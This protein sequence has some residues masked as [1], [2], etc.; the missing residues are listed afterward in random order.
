MT[1]LRHVVLLVQSAVSGLVALGA[2]VF[3]LASHSPQLGFLAAVSAM[4]ALVPVVVAAGLGA[5]WGWARGLGIGYELLLLISG[6]TDT[7]V[8]HNDDV[9]A[10]V[11]NVVLPASLLWM[12][13]RRQPTMGTWSGAA[14][15]GGSTRS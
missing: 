10:T 6:V 2:S 4:L 15:Q 14:S 5:G 8:L 1:S 13:M 11:V 3:A 7:L 9:I 12:L